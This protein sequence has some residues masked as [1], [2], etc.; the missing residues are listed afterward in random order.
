MYGWRGRIGHVYPAVVAET[1]FT[2]FFRVVPEGVTLAMAHLSIEAIREED[3]RRSQAQLDQAIAKKAQ[4]EAQ[5]AN[6]RAIYAN[7]AKQLGYT[8]IRA[9]FSGVVSQKQ[10]SAGDVVSPGGAL[11]T[12]GG[13]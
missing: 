9:P 1:Y 8:Q 3:L 2:D 12:V 5:L 10:V 4:D 11:F 6:A 13:R 7:A